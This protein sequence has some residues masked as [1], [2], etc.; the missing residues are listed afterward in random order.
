MSGDIN[1]LVIFTTGLLLGGL[2][3]L[4][5]QGGLLATTLAQREGEK[6]NNLLPITS[7]IVA[8]LIA[9][10][11]LGALLGWLGSLVQLSP[12]AYLILQFAVVIFM[13][14]TALNLL[15]AHP[16]FRYFMIQPPHFL[17]R[18]IRKQSKR[19]DIF[20]P[21]LLGAFTIFIPC[22]ATQAMM[23]LAV[24]AGNPLAGAAILFTF[25][26]G[27]SPLFFLLGY[28]TMRV[29]DV[30]KERFTKV[31]A[32]V[33]IVLALFNLNNALALTG[34]PYTFSNLLEKA[35]CTISY[36]KK[37]LAGMPV[38]E[39]TI[40][41]TNA[42]YSPSSFVVATGSTVTLTLINK[43]ATGCQQAFTIPKLGIHKIVAPNRVEHLT[44]TAPENASDL[45]FMCSMGMYPGVVKVIE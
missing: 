12:Q 42:G 3:C 15:H 1:L 38:T 4:A 35:F 26:L 2:G 21:A 14:G 10:T 7:F 9:Y 29:G 13:L 44:F 45:A 37:D 17:G 33:L 39:Q 40:F 22:G 20:T 31:A 28:F 8:K 23:A 16:L 32:G 43:N 5:V 30:L 6:T 19:G 34:T 24:A 18:F 36:C 25:I 41:I 11:I 27:T